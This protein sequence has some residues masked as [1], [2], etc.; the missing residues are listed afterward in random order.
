MGRCLPKNLSENGRRILA[1]L[2]DL[3]LKPEAVAAAA[4]VSPS[5]LYRIMS[6]R[7]GATYDPRLRTK[8]RLAK[9]LRTP[10]ADLFDEAQLEMLEEPRVSM[11]RQPEVFARLIV[12]QLRS[13]QEPLRLRAARAAAYALVDMMLAVSGIGPYVDEDLHADHGNVDHLERQLLDLYHRLPT[14]V[15]RQAAQMAIRAILNIESVSRRQPSEALY[16]AVARTRWSEKRIRRDRPPLT[17][18][19]RVDSASS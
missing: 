14:S 1:R 9:A 6:A 2:R 4:G 19:P 17:D 16:R 18:P 10:M 5:T 12:H 3:D 15:R 11:Q 7:E 8:R 13:V